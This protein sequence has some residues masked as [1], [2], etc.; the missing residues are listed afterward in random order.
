MIRVRG[1]RGCEAEITKFHQKSKWSAL[2]ITHPGL[3]DD[4]EGS[5]YPRQ[6]V[7]TQ[8]HGTHAKNPVERRLKLM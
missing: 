2:K 8:T 1:F 7:L 4:L 5:F 3:I 6:I